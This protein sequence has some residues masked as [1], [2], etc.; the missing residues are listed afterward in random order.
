MY[1]SIS[2]SFKHRC[3]DVNNRSLHNFYVAALELKRKT[4]IVC[5][6]MAFILNPNLN[7]KK[8]KVKKSNK[9]NASVN[10]SLL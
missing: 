4:G 9:C 2:T 5:K 8:D 1:S 3:D 7:Y 6:L 10:H